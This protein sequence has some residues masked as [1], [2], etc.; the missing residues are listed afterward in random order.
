MSK[1][2]AETETEA[3]DE[4][5]ARASISSNLPQLSQFVRCFKRQNSKSTQERIRSKIWARKMF[6]K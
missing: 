6:E 5:E 1:E 2:A 3:E 4:D